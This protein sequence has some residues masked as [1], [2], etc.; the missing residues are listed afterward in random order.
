MGDSN[1]DR[2]LLIIQLD[3][4]DKKKYY[5]MALT[6]SLLVR[7]VQYPLTL[8]RTRLQIQHGKDVYKGSFDA[9]RKI[10]G[11][12]GWRGLYRGFAINSIQSVNSLIYISVYE[13]VRQI[14]MN[15]DHLKEF[16]YQSY[17][18][19]FMSG[20]CA[21]FASQTIAVPAD[22]VSQHMMLLGGTKSV[23]QKVTTKLESLQR[24]RIDDE[25]KHKRINVIQAI[26]SEVYRKGGIL[27]FYKGYLVSL[28]VYGFGS[29]IWWPFYELYAH[30]LIPVAPSFVPQTLVHGFSASIAG[31]TSVTI[32]NVMELTR[33]RMQVGGTD[34]M[35]T[36]RNTWREERLGIFTKGLTARI[37]NIIPFSFLIM[38]SYS[39][40]KHLSLKEEYRSQVHW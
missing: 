36:M 28:S 12:E 14:M 18:S 10:K 32:T 7:F 15:W 25:V 23:P 4:M 38:T 19:S 26:I 5:P 3:M 13:N 39:S 11:T 17:I 30:N 22:I 6:S 2:K 35:E 9:F 34:F 8:I 33:V 21:S 31:I 16:Q 40:I 24:I 29:A 1:K 37:I 27:G 20:F